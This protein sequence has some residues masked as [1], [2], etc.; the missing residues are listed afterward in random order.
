M[1]N[2]NEILANQ[3]VDKLKE[4]KLINAADKQL[5]TKLANGNMKEADWKIAFE[6]ITNK[7]KENTQR[8][9]EAE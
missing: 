7:P 1:S 3:I 5:A 4:E 8:K 6:E 2:I 9:N